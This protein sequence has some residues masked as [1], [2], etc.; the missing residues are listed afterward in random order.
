MCETSWCL[1]ETP[2]HGK[3]YQYFVYDKKKQ[4]K[5]AVDDKSNFFNDEHD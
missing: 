4:T 5:Y 2:V 1:R 3:K